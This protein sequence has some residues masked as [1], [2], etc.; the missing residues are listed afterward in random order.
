MK[1][2]KKTLAAV[3]AFV[4]AVTVALSVTSGTVSAASRPKLSKKKVV[5]TITDVKKK[6]VVTLKVKGVSKKTAK[7][8]RWSTSNK[9]VATVKKGKVTAKKAG[10]ATITCKVKGRK[11]TCKVTVK[12]KRT[13]GRGKLDVAIKSLGKVD[14]TNP[15]TL[16]RIQ[17]DPNGLAGYDKVESN[18]YTEEQREMYN[19]G[20]RKILFSKA[21]RYVVNSC[22]SVTYNGKDVT[23]KAEYIIWGDADVGTIPTFK[24][25]IWDVGPLLS[26]CIDDNPQLIVTY[27][28]VKKTIPLKVTITNKIIEMCYCGFLYEN[29]EDRRV[30]QKSYPMEDFYVH[31]GFWG[32]DYNIV[33][34]EAR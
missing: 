8:A 22:V 34:V 29:R 18:T 20:S 14:M 32:F 19:N 17:L 3:M 5:L 33:D 7:K 12:D 26:G 15:E 6:P 11:Y 1:I 30:H 10:K 24:N 13:S 23:D 4:L 2:T 9:S 31:G 25:G 16:K 27:K 28:G 21:P